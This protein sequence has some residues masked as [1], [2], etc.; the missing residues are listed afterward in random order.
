MANDQLTTTL[1]GGTQTTTQSP[2]SASNT[3]NSGAQPTGN[4]QTSAASNLQGGLQINGASLGNITLN[5]PGSTAK[6]EAKTSTATPLPA[7]VQH[8]H[9]NPL[10]F[11]ISGILL[12]IAAVL[13]WTT[14]RAA[15]NTTDYS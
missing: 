5:V 6:A 1:G 10:L 2:Q 11:G 13:L 8:H 4:L 3:A 7:V 12:V 14:A 9:T 15:K